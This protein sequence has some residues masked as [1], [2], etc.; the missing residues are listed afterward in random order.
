[1]PRV[2]SSARPRCSTVGRARRLRRRSSETTVYEFT[3]TALDE[4]A[5]SEPAIAIKLMTNLAR[6]MSIRMRETNE[7][8]RELEDSRG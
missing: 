2:R 5:R 3:R 4:I 8:L 6:L 7:I 1:M